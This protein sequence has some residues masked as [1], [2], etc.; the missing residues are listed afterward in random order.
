M[1]SFRHSSVVNSP[2]RSTFEAKLIIFKF[3]PDFLIM[4]TRVACTEALQYGLFRE[5]QSEAE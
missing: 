1:I 3:T 2:L 4:A 5:S